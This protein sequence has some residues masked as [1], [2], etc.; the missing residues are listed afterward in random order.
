MSESLEETVVKLVP[1]TETDL[2]KAK[3]D[4]RNIKARKAPKNNVS[5]LARFDESM[6]KKIKAIPAALI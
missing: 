3:K 4:P 1:T 6:M 2:A 5:Q